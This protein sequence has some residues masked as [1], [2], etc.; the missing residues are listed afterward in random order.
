MQKVWAMIADIVDSRSVKERRAFQRGLKQTLK[1][2]SEASP[3]VYLSPLTITLG[4]EFQAVYG[5]FSVVLPH[6]LEILQF[7]APH[8]LRVALAYGELT[9]D[10]NPK[11]A[12]EMD[13]PAF[14]LARDCMEGLK[15]RQSTA[16]RIDGLPEDRL[17]LI[18]AAC[19]MLANALN[20]WKPVTLRIARGLQNGKSVQILSEMLGITPRAVHKNI[21]TN[22]VR[23]ILAAMDAISREVRDLTEEKGGSR[24]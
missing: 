6:M 9:T 2:L 19:S 4:D 21:A 24:A 11:A 1:Q 15:K 17:P 13:G 20:D 7:L 12:L 22:H 8:K 10:I 18:N 5:D 16:L 14:N 23:D 3:E